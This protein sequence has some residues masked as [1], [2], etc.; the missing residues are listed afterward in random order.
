FNGDNSDLA[1]DAPIQVFDSTDTI[2]L[3]SFA[4]DHLDDAVNYANTHAGANVI[5]LQSSASPFSAQTWPVDITQAVTI[6][7]VGGTATVSAGGHS[8]FAIEPGAVAGATDT[9][10]LEGL[11]IAGDGTTGGTVGVAFKGAYEGPSDGAIELVNTSVSNFGQNGV[12]ITG[13]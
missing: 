11:N 12:V 13:G 4:K 2:L 7:A 3:A 5:E 10:H 6:K 9:V 8:A 1:L